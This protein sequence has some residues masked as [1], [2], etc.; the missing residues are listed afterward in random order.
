MKKILFAILFCLPILANAKAKK[1]DAPYLAGAVP[2]VNGVV[3][4]QESFRVPGKSSIQIHDVMKSWIENLVENSIPAPTNYARVVM[5]EPDTIV[6][7]VCE[8]QVFTKRFLN[9]D[10]ARFR[11]T[12]AVSIDGD[13]V[14]ITQTGLAW[15]YGEDMEGNRGDTYRAEEWINDANALNKTRDK[16]LPR[17]GKFRRKTIDRFNELMESAM[18]MFEETPKMV[19]TEQKKVRKAVSVD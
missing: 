2:E 8:W 1:D 14:L 15:Y 13:R 9:L 10:R 12:L 3:T 5:D 16:L 18:D 7:K 4:F 11:Y 17:S 19:P 6:A